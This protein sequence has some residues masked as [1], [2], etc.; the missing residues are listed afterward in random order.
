M[1]NL[2]PWYALNIDVS[3][4][5]RTDLNFRQ[6]LDTANN[7]KL[8]SVHTWYFNI[9]NLPT[10]LNNQWLDYMKS[11]N[12]PIQDLL[13]FYREPGYLHPTAHIDLPYRDSAKLGAALNWCVGTD[14]AEMVWYNLPEDPGNYD[15]TEA[16]S[17]YREW[18]L[19]DLTECSRR[20]IG[21]QCTMVRVD[22]PHNVVMNTHPR[23]LISARTLRR[24]DNWND[25]VDFIKP[26][27][28]E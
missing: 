18:P 7:K 5:V 19:A 10:I 21:S 2:K 16:N 9:E 27:I 4:A 17:N 8:S 25:A 14:D 1:N 28:T 20:T 13:V 12:I 15:V 26:F 11:I 23:W 24:I 3:N 22:V 6:M